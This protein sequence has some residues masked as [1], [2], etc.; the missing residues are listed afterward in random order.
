MGARVRL[1]D[2]AC[3][4]RT[5]AFRDRPW[6][7]TAPQ[8]AALAGLRVRTVQHWRSIGVYV[9]ALPVAGTVHA[10]GS[11]YGLGDVFVLR[12]LRDVIDEGVERDLAARALAGL[13]VVEVDGSTVIFDFRKIARLR[14]PWWLRVP[15]C[16]WLLDRIGADLTLFTSEDPASIELPDAFTVRDDGRFARIVFDDEVLVEVLYPASRVAEGL[17][18]AADA[19][20][21]EHRIALKDRAPWL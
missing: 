9:P 1:L 6:G 13:A 20:H 19:W 15:A 4:V 5:R 3:P 16:G 10:P 8:A 2:A 7:W 11:L 18:E 14:P 17:V 12:A 21:R